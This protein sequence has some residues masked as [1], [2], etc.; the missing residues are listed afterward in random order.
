MN[1]VVRNLVMAVGLAVPAGAVVGTS[2]SSPGSAS[3]INLPH[4]TPIPLPT[5]PVV[6]TPSPTPFT[7]PSG[8]GGFITPGGNQN[9]GNSGTS[10]VIVDLATLGTFC[11]PGELDAFATTDLANAV[12]SFR[13][14]IGKTVTRDNRL[15]ALAQTDTLA[16]IAVAIPSTTIGGRTITQRVKTAVPTSKAAAEIVVKGCFPTGN[17][18]PQIVALILS[19]PPNPGTVAIMNNP[20]WT[21][22]GVNVMTDTNFGGVIYVIIF[23]QE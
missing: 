6:V 3:L 18:I 4:P 2:I 23:A 10:G 11:T 1:N 16:Y 8:G 9:N 12:M 22:F 7:S 5:G 20:N 15:D 13:T 17:T 19:N 14:S 21:S